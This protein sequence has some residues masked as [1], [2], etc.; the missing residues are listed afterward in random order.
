MLVA[1]L[2]WIENTSLSSELM[3]P[4]CLSGVEKTLSSPLR[5]P[6]ILNQLKA[7][8][9]ILN[10]T[11][12]SVNQISY[13]P[14]FSR[15]SVHKWTSLT[16]MWLSFQIWQCGGEIEW[17][18]CSRVAHVYRNHM[19]YNFGKIDTKIPVI[20]VVSLQLDLR[21]WF[22]ICKFYFTWITK[23]NNTIG[24]G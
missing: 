18:P 4:D 8:V 20:Q 16:W 1:C 9:I 10:K 6:T 22:L 21:V 17:V 13:N 14:R 3:T 23:Q 11:I 2:L 24:P 15:R 12:S 7:G 19:P 5:Y